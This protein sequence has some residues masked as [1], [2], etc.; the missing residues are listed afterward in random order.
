MK[1]TQKLRASPILVARFKFSPVHPGNYMLTTDNMDLHLENDQLLVT[2][3]NDNVLSAGPLV[4]VGYSLRGSVSSES[5]PVLGVKFLLFP[6]TKTTKVRSGKYFHRIVL[7]AP[8][9]PPSPYHQNFESK[10]QKFFA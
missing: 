10:F 3:T 1:V 7:R 4:V 2:V 9:C 6:E 8:F 5:E